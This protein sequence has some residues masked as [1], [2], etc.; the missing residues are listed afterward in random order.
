[1][2]RNIKRDSK[3]AFP[4]RAYLQANGGSRRLTDEEIG[5][6]TAE[7]FQSRNLSN[8]IAKYYAINNT[9]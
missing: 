8:H 4:M 7:C 3:K 5:V 6:C 1:M 9:V 2:S